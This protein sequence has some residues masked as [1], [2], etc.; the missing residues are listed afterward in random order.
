[1][2]RMDLNAVHSASWKRFAHFANASPR[3]HGSLPPSSLDGTFIRPAVG[4][5]DSTAEAIDLIRSI[6]GLETT[7]KFV[8]VKCLH[9]LAD[10][11]RPSE[12]GGQLNN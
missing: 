3:T 2:H 1:M 6:N 12:P 10:R 7:L 8:C 4:R 11:E 9:Q 5:R